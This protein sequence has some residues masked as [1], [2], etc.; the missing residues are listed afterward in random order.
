MDDPKEVLHSGLRS[1]RG[2]LLSKLDGLSEREARR[3]RTP[4]GTSL[5]GLVKH[6]AAI[7]AGYFAIAFDRPHGLTMPWDAPDASHDDNLDMF[8]AADETMAGLL[9]WCA[10]CFAHADAVIAELPIDAPGT[11]PWWPEDRRH[12]TLGQVIQH[13][14]LDE[15]RHAGHAD[16]L[17]EQLDGVVGLHTPGNNLPDWTPERWRTHVAEL[18]RIAAA[19]G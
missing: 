9:D 1:Q 8:A 7:E 3:P 18:E 13:V 14:A 6:C 2:A 17:R 10:R 12:V 16:I 4:T 5:L 11:V 15:A 19:H